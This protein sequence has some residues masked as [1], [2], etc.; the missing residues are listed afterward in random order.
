MSLGTETPTGAATTGP[1]TFSDTSLSWSDA[2]SASD[3]SGE[4]TPAASA[5]ADAT[6][7][8][9]TAA[10]TDGNQPGAEA[11]GEPPKERWDDI[12]NNA[13]TKTRAEVEAEYKQK[14]GWAES[15]NPTE[16]Q[17]IQQWAR[18]YQSDPIAWF[19]QTAAELRQ[20]F[21]HLAQNLHSEA[22]RVLAGARSNPQQAAPTDIEPDIPV[23][24]EQ[25]RVVSQAFSAD[26][27]KQL[28]AHA[29]QDAIG[30]E[31][32]PMKADFQSR[33]QQEQARQEQAQ[34]ESSVKSIYEQA[35]SELPQFKENE[36]E[37]AKALAEIP[38]DPGTALYRAWAKVVLP[39]Y[40]AQSKADVLDSFKQKAAAKTEAPSAGAASPMTRPTNA[41]DLEKTIAHLAASMSR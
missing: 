9:A 10:P 12:L 3:P 14:Y 20:Q 25:G 8:P 31:V 29:V 39:K 6:V 15:V 27:V 19:A 11:K 38:G 24:D 16:F 23:V 33:Q 41:R 35:S 32:A 28:I 13:R 7:P 4:S 5:S 22:A 40:Q 26:R 1:T 21:P 17:Q 18:Q 36:A 30:K 34:I 37:I 2:S